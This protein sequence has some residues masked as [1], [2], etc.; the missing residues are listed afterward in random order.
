MQTHVDEST[1]QLRRACR[2]ENSC[3][4]AYGVFLFL[5]LPNDGLSPKEQPNGFEPT[6]DTAYGRSCFDALMQAKVGRKRKPKKAVHKESRHVI[7]SISCRL[8]AGG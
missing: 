8:T 2:Y 7:L 4:V 6:L 1:L 3:V 5:P